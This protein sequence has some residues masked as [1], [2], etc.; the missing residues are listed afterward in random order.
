[1]AFVAAIFPSACDTTF[2]LAALLL[3]PYFLVV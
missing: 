2:R 3:P 1:M